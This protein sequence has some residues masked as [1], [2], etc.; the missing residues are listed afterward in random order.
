MTGSIV[1][2]AWLRDHLNDPDLIILDASVRENK[3]GLKAEYEDVQIPGARF[4]D[5]EQAFSDT[6]SELPNTI[7]GP[8]QF[9]KECRKLGVNRSSRIVVYDNMGIFT[10]PRA[11]WLLKT[12]GHAEVSV[13]DGGLPA[14]VAEGC[15][16]EPIQR[17]EYNE[18]DFTVDFNPD[19]VRDINFVNDNLDQ[20]E[21]LIVDARSEGRFNGTAPEP[22]EGMRS[23]HI[24]H[25]VNIPF[26]KVL[27]NGKMKSKADLMEVFNTI[28]HHDKPLVFS[29][30]SGITACIIMLASEQVLNNKKAVYDGSWSEWAASNHPIRTKSDQ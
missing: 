11:W 14:W 16:I 15:Q 7:P 29:C 19:L 9:E 6:E 10:S 4:F 23:G 12:M 2:V 25:S 21:A 26:Q 24:P 17:K 20:K 1:S 3:I 30:G 28:D 8:E 5:F 13:L 18:G 27:D 22:R